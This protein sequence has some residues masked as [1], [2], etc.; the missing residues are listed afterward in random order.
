MISYHTLAVGNKVQVF[1]YEERLDD[2][3][4]GLGADAGDCRENSS[5][6]SLTSEG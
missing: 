1:F 4:A 3:P 6:A 5:S 2:G